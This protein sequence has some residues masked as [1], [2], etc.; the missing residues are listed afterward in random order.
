MRDE[1]ASQE[2]TILGT[3]Q[4]VP[5]IRKEAVYNN[6]GSK[7]LLLGMVQMNMTVP[8]QQEGP[9]MSS[10]HVILSAAK[11]LATHSDALTKQ[12][13][14]PKWSVLQMNTII[15]SAVGADYAD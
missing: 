10:S 5:T 14:H 7:L 2:D 1:N 4:F 15:R 3:A 11:Y 12:S 13:G 9:A 6:G 8:H